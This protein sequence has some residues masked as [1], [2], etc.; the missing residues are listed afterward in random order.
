MG[1]DELKRKTTADEKVPEIDNQQ[2]HTRN[3]AQQ[4]RNGDD[5]SGLYRSEDRGTQYHQTS[6]SFNVQRHIY[7]E[8]AMNVQERM[9]DPIESAE[10][11]TPVNSASYNYQATVYFPKD[12]LE[13]KKEFRR[14]VSETYETSSLINTTSNDLRMDGMEAGA[15]GRSA[16]IFQEN[17]LEIT[18][19]ISYLD[20]NSKSFQKKENAILKKQ[21]RN[22]KAIH[23]L[24]ETGLEYRMSHKPWKHRLIY[25]KEG[26]RPLRE[27]WH[28]GL[29][30]DQ[31]HV[32]RNIP[33]RG[34]L[35][36]QT[37]KVAYT[38]RK[39]RQRLQ[40]NNYTKDYLRHRLNRTL[41]NMKDTAMGSQFSEDEVI[42]EV[43]R[44]RRLI[45]RGIGWRLRSDVRRLHRELD[46][47]QTLKYRNI[48]K[49]A[50][51][52]RAEQLR[53]KSG[54]DLQKR[55]VEE[56]AKQ[57]LI[58]EQYKHK[59]KKKMIRE[60]KHEQG[61]FFVRIRK[62]HQLKKTIKKEKQIRSKRT[63]ALVASGIAI[64]FLVLLV[65]FLIVFFMMVLLDTG[66]D[67]YVKSTSQNDYYT[68]TD[69]TAYFREKEAE[70][71][72]SLKPEN[73][74]PQILE[75]NPEIYEFIYVLDDISF[76]ANTL[77]AYLSA[78][79]NEFT[80]EMVQD[81]L[82]ELFEQ[83]YTL[84]VKIKMEER[85]VEDTTQPKDPNTGLYPKVRKMV[86]ICY[87][88]LEKQDFYELCKS[89]I[90]D[91]AKQGQ[92][93]VFYLT[94]NGQQIYGPVMDVDWRNKISSNYG[95]RIHPITG[96]RIFHDGVDIAVPV[97]TILYSPVMGTVV[98]S[99]YSD[100]AG[101][102][103]TIQTETGWL[104]TF[105]HMDSRTVQAGERIERGQQVGFSG[106]TGNSTGPHLHIRVHDA[107]GNS[108]N[109]VFI[110]PFSTIEA[111]ES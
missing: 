101:N 89:R 60:Y 58:N 43:N 107:E 94:G 36:F 78:K 49:D 41:K 28:A 75:E 61:N 74:E 15:F 68:M 30:D 93:D 111:S 21:Q 18:K 47:Y 79:Y 97:G 13:E 48:R 29:Q 34:R 10:S 76:D 62:Q 5:Q 12:D 88:I 70:L 98:A 46:G 103:V 37:E 35:K 57:K 17:D 63:R 73:I 40:N 106:N 27:S 19:S 80:M 6:Q 26:K 31:I 64:L 108:V 23:R 1:Q 104:I 44:K 95:E 7:A 92:M 100:S 9:T 56:A 87:V 86:Q 24:E 51:N 3:N 90:D 83:Y 67:A 109:P 42:A 66:S 71:E 85:L 8:Q 32:T 110:I 105:M 4:F 38:T 2:F 53:Y 52:A 55:K 99:H 11:I 14:Y 59:L 45:T 96:K 16:S 102:M 33:V 22:E 77:I 65:F 84:R 72:E 91:A 20:G 39:H 25:D 69:A 50:L 81:D 54:I 82:N